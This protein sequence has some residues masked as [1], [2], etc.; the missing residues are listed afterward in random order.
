MRLDNFQD[1]RLVG[2]EEKEDNL[3]TKL[4]ARKLKTLRQPAYENMN[5]S[6]TS[7]ARPISEH[8]TILP[9]RAQGSP[10]LIQHA[11]AVNTTWRASSEMSKITPKNL[12][13]DNSLPPFLARLQANNA[14]RDGRHEFRVA[15]PKKAR[16]AEDEAEDEPVYFDEATAES[17]TRKEW[18][19]KDAE[20]ER[21]KELGP[22]AEGEILGQE[23]EGK[24]KAEKEKV[25]AI[26]GSKKR[27]MGKIIG[28]EEEVDK[29]GESKTPKP[30][31]RKVDR[32]RLSKKGKKIK[33]SFGDDE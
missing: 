23:R 27:K 25:A 5:L 3:M 10:K 32:G 8:F 20:Q 18:E 2:K 9:S 1:I 26:G 31:D 21:E 4:G 13:Y 17:L 14:S 24:R 29:A 6:R 33:L 28:G 22:E 30:E 19:D 11:R 15:R 12:Q 16:N 7:K